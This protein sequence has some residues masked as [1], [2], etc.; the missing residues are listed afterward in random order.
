MN[1][2]LRTRMQGGVVGAGGEKPP[3]YP[4]MW[5]YSIVHIPLSPAPSLVKKYILLCFPE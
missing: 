4:I 2:P 1:R 5:Q 3:G